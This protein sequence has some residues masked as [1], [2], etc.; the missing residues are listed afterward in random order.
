MIIRRPTFFELRFLR[1][2]ANFQFGRNAGYILIPDNI[3]VSISPATRRIRHVLIE[4]KIVLTLRPSDALF[5]LHILGGKLLHENYSFPM[6]RVVVR[7][8]VASFIAEGRDVFAKHVVNVD[9]KVEAGDEVII[10][11]EDDR[12]LAVGR[13]KLS[14]SEML[15][16]KR[17]IAVRVRHAIRKKG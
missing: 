3:L 17:G 15:S 14:P 6:F 5:S 10:V 7:K 16:L 11:D 2:I 9:K 8:D 4:D 13:C 1:G 12:F